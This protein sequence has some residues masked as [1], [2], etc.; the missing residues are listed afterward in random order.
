MK[1]VPE[2]FGFQ[3]A[4]NFGHLLTRYAGSGGNERLCANRRSRAVEFAVRLQ[5]GQLPQ[6]LV[7]RG[8]LHKLFYNG[9]D[10]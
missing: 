9:E 4:G 5:R 2:L 7:A 8:L 10:V 6:A 1:F 3:T